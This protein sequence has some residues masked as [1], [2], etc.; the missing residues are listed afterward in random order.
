MFFQEPTPDTSG[1]MIAGYAIA[2][3]VMALYVASIYLRS[4]NLKQDLT[5]LEEMEEPAPAAKPR[6]VNPLPKNSAPSQNNRSAKP[7]TKR[8][9]RK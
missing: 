3:L 5:V 6:T 2:F 8:S 4:R 9:K 1:Y 7:V